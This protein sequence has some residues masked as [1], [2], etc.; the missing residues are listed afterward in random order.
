MLWEAFQAG[1]LFGAQASLG[2]ME[3]VVGPGDTLMGR[4][5]SHIHRLLL[6]LL[7]PGSEKE[8]GE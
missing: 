4:G 3:V 6:F 8:E 2:Q 1:K 7:A 5:A